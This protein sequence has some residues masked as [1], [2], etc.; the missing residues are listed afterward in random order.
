MSLGPVG[1]SL[2][3]GLAGAGRT[4]FRVDAAPPLVGLSREVTRDRLK[5]LAR[6]GWVKRLARGLYMV[7]PLEAGPQRVWT[8]DPALIA[9]QVVVPSYLSFW[10]ALSFHGLTEQV[11]RVVTVA[12]RRSHA[13]VEIL[14]LR[15][16]F[17]ALSAR[18][19]FGFEATWVGHQQV[20]VATPEKAILDCLDHPERAG[21][22]SEVAKALVSLGAKLDT[23][24]LLR[25][26]GRM[27]VGAV[28]KR[29]GF[30]LEILEIRTDLLRSVKKHILAGYSLLDPTL[31]A[32]G[33]YLARW[34]LRLN[35]SA[36][37]ILSGIGT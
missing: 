23:R 24:R 22:V 10:S 2:L 7:V 37:E 35:V 36:N 16:L 31:A 8:E 17:T 20:P 26:L 5:T 33:R 34:N 21:G 11:P 4:V 32:R 14:G 28:A 13:P 3:L 15:Y 9:S 18:K 6:Q 19:F 29:L 25:D 1:S 12:T 30:L 27:R